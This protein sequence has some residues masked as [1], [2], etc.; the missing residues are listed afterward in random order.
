MDG[1]WRYR[2]ASITG[3][4]VLVALAVS[5]VNRP[6]VQETFARVPYF[7][8]PAPMVLSTGDLL[9]AIGTAVVVALFAL[10]PL[11]KPRPRRILDTVLETQRRV[12]LTMIALAALGYFNYSYRLP[13][14]T[15]MLASG[16]LL[17]SMPILFVAIRRRPDAVGRALLVGDDPEAMRDILRVSDAPIAGYVSPSTL[18]LSRQEPDESAGS[19]R[20]TETASRHGAISRIGGFARFEDVIAEND[21]DTV[22]LAFDSPDRA[23]FFGTLATCHEHGLRARIHR[24]HADTVLCPA[25]AKGDLVDVHLEP[26]DLQDRLLKRIFDVAFAGL[27][28]LVLAPLLAIIAVAIRLDTQGPILYRQQRTAAFGETFTVYKFRSMVPDAESDSGVTV[29][30]EDAGGVDHRVTRV[31]RVL[32]NTHFDEIP[33]LWS[34][35][36]GDMSVVGPRPERPELDADIEAE[37]GV[38]QWRR[39]WFVKP[40]L[41]GLAQIRGATGHEP[42]VKLRHDIEYIRHQSFWFDLRIVIRQLWQVWT[43]CVA[44]LGDEFGRSDDSSNDEVPT[45]SKTESAPGSASAT[46]PPSTDREDGSV[47]AQPPVND[48]GRTA[49]EHSQD[50]EDHQQ[51]R[52]DHQQDRDKLHEDDGQ[53]RQENEERHNDRGGR[54]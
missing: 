13:R 37:H 32:R 7:G 31:G 35:L 19:S 17:V 28:L 34:I 48:G 21:V 49:G 50:R 10:W 46:E 27:A 20:Q 11:Y 39:R 51:D 6:A 14:S 22:L 33:Q 36:V 2:L 15:L 54:P 8:R 53:H 3:T 23:E 24:E 38:G 1:R 26:W 29:S 25:T 30:D 42:A 45:P 41:T 52:E 4:V 43:D 18:D 9:W 12:L 47:G 5:I 40:G 16:F 44:L